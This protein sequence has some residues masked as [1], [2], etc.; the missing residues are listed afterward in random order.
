MKKIL[1]VLMSMMFIV[2]MMATGASALSFPVKDG[3]YEVPITLKKVDKDSGELVME[4]GSPKNSMAAEVF[5]PKGRLEI[6]N[7]SATI[8]MP[9]SQNPTTAMPGPEFTPADLENMIF[10]Y[11]TNGKPVGNSLKDAQKMHKVT[12]DGTT[13]DLAYKMPVLLDNYPGIL[14]SIPKKGI[15]AHIPGMPDTAKAA[16]EIDYSH[17]KFIASVDSTPAGGSA[18]PTKKKVVVTKIVRV[19]KKNSANTVTKPGETTTAVEET[20][21]VDES[22]TL[23]ETTTKKAASNKPAKEEQKEKKTVWPWVVGAVVVVGVA[24]GVG[25]VIAKKKGKI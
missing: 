14:F 4:N 20:S 3:V 1:A 21:V 25:V 7:G 9:V 17:A 24:A 15:M 18:S 16:M 13:Y 2:S 8:I 11:Y 10:Q 12:V 19:T 5:A 23:A 22:T 6:N